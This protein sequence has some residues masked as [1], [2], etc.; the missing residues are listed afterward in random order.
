MAY[1]YYLLERLYPS[2]LSDLE[3]F[4][5]KELTF[6]CST[7]G[8]NLSNY[9]AW[10][11]RSKYLDKLLIH[12][13]YCRSSLVSNKWHL[14]LS[15][16]YTDCSNQAAWFYARWLLFKQLDIQTINQDEHIK[17]LEELNKIEPGNK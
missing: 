5:E 11:Y 16:V 12:N 14:V 2:F 9:S 15:A 3:T 7:I 13:P 8:V 4:Y 17:S 1:R 10:H 6:L